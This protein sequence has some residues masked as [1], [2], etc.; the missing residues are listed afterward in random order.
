[1][2][3]GFEAKP[4]EKSKDKR[5]RAYCDKFGLEAYLQQDRFL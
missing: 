5:L 4:L 1:M 2:L 3:A